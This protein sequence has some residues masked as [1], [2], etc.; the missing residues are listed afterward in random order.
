ELPSGGGT[1]HQGSSKPDRDTHIKGGVREGEVDRADF[2]E[3][4][5]VDDLELMDRIF[6]DSN[7]P[8]VLHPN[9]NMPSGRIVVLTL[10]PNACRPHHIQDAGRKAEQQKHDHSPRRDPKYAVERPA[11]GGANQDPGHKFAGKPKPAR[12]S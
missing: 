4:K 7:V 12:V 8:S 2:A 1:K 6:H 3:R 11:D 10:G 9:V 5:I